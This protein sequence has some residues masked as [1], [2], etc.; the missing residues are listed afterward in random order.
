MRIWK[1]AL[2]DDQL[3]A[4]VFMGP[5]VAA[6]GTVVG[7]AGFDLAPG[8][9]FHVYG[10]FTTAGTV[11]LGEGSKI[12]FDAE[13][14]FTAGSFS[15]PSG[16]LADYIVADPG[17]Y[18]TP[19]IS[20]NTITVTQKSLVV[21][22]ASWTGGG[23]AGDVTDPANWNCTDPY[24][25]PITGVP[26]S[27][28]AVTIAGTGIN[29]QAPVGTTLLA[30]TITIGACTLGADCD[31]RGFPVTPSIASGSVNLNGHNLHL[32]S[33]SGANETKFS[34]TTSG[35]LYLET[36][37][38]DTTTFSSWLY[39]GYD[40]HK[41]GAGNLDVSGSVSVG[42]GGTGSFVH[43]GGSTTVN[44]WMSI[45]HYNNAAA[46]GTATVTNG[47]LVVKDSIH[48]GYPAGKDAYGALDVGPGGI[49]NVN[50]SGKKL[51]F[52][53]SNSSLSVRDGGKVIGTVINNIGGVTMNFT[54]SGGTIQGTLENNSRAIM[55][56]SDCTTT[57]NTVKNDANATMTISNA[58]VNGTLVATSGRLTTGGNVTVKH[59][60]CND[61]GV[62]AAGGNTVLNGYL[63]IGHN[64]NTAGSC[65]VANGSLTV[66]DTLY[67]GYG[68][69]GH[70]DVGAGGVVTAD[71]ANG[72][73][74]KSG[75]MTVHDG[76][77]V[78]ARW[79]VDDDSRNCPVTFDGG[80]IKPTSNTTG[81]YA[82]QFIKNVTDFTIGANGMTIDTTG[83]AL[84]VVGTTFKTTT[85]T[86][87]ITVTNG[88]SVNL[89]GATFRLSAKPKSPFTLA[90]AES[91]SV[92]TGALPTV[93]LSDGSAFPGTVKFS[94]DN[95]AI[96]VVPDAVGPPDPY[97]GAWTWAGVSD[98]TFANLGNWKRDGVSASTFVDALLLLPAGASQAFTYIGWDPVVLQTTTL[99]IDGAAS[100]GDVGGFYLNGISV[101]ASGR[102]AYDPTKFTFRLAQPPV[103]ASGAKIALDAKYAASTR[104]RFLLMTWN[105]GSLDMD[106]VA[107]TA[108]FD[109]TSARGANP[110][111]WA[112]NLAGGGGRLWLDLDYGAPKSRVNVLCVGD[113]ITHGNDGN[114]LCGQGKNGGWGNWRTGLMK[115]LAAAG[116]EPV[117]KGHRWEE[118]HDICGATMPDEWISHAGAG[119]QRLVRGTIDQIENTLDQA[120]DVDFVLC[121]I[122]TNDMGG[123]Q[124][125][126]LFKVWTNLVWKVLN[127]KPSAKFIAG[128]VV[129]I[130][131]NPSLDARVVAYNALVSNAVANA[132]FPARR[133][134]FA[135]LYTTCY[136]YDSNGNEIAGAFY[137]DSVNILHPDWP[138]NDKIADTYCATILKALSDDPQFTPGQA[139]TGVPTTS[140][141]KRNVPYAYR[142]GFVR[143][144]VLDV[145]ANNGV[146]LATLGRI[147]YEDIGDTG[148]ATNDIRRVGYYI[149]LKRK[150][151]ALH[152]YHGLVRWI[153]VSMDA[154]GDKSIETVGVPLNLAK[155]Y[156]GTAANLRIASNMPGINAT[157][158]DAVGVNGWIE[159]WPSSY[160]SGASGVAGAPGNTHGYDWNDTCG[161][162]ASG[163]GSMQVH[164]LTPGETNPAQVLF[165]FN[166][167]TVS[168]NYEI[169][170]G[171][172]SHVS[173]GSVDWTFAAE[174]F[175]GSQRMS[176]AAYEV[177]RIEIWTMS[178]TASA[179]KDGMSIYLR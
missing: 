55:N 95:T 175:A 91:G 30:D 145:A 147:P 105:G 2:S 107:L 141:A 122:G 152:Q 52:N 46:R 32:A 172:F 139:E 44:S 77:T 71:P 99:L 33:L 170:L 47:T 70:L 54:S 94:A 84:S 6:P 156:Q 87:A 171:N 112:E 24:G 18:E 115:K 16:T 136:R 63:S 20:G 73:V 153:W 118:S 64:S 97:D 162:G 85:G 72:L 23:T 129:D 159:F 133:V 149:E 166:R 151:D 126:A 43:G 10:D 38:G 21:A 92:F 41:T 42:Y 160:G 83:K 3:T 146:N 109:A 25:D 101:G 96:N 155:R 81:N 29:L 93:T 50:F 178:E 163:Y 4:N 56:I 169:G 123:T 127:Q 137:D 39:K 7:N 179:D 135:D 111:V 48:L 36:P 62:F 143:A 68:G 26:A 51:Y 45:G 164:L 12:Q 125:S 161:G 49:V 69:T 116:Y 103:F 102:I 31:W 59:V 35:G 66:K 5:D 58:T 168:G 120:G 28:T 114:E 158:A 9:T 60:Q 80:V 79:F 19:V 14:V 53:N 15:L 110:K 74:V 86:R 37:H 142:A 131:Y 67:V 104:G 88:G 108:V 124:P 22:T 117:A 65:T 13:A 8:A 144:R 40:A 61:D 132:T 82:T 27:V 90:A 134:Y 176:A 128:A 167:W 174:K 119:G 98:S 106:E 177:A 140:G 165:A 1:G 100:F 57:I 89:S 78:N 154:F 138:N 173:L 148:A 17:A 121:K 75:T 157:S 11:T 34:G 76:G 113:S 130:A 150:D